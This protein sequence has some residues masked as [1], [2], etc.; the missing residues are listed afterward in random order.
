MGMSSVVR[1]FKRQAEGPEWAK[2]YWNWFG[3]HAFSDG[4][5]LNEKGKQG[6]KGDRARGVSRLLGWEKGTNIWVGQVHWSLRI[7]D[8]TNGRNDHTAN[9]YISIALPAL[10]PPSAEYWMQAHP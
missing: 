8:D 2:S 4:D 3:T 9:I 6:L 7:Y 1:E 10:R 5:D